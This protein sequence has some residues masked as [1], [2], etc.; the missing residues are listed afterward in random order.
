MRPIAFWKERAHLYVITFNRYCKNINVIIVGVFRAVTQYCV[1]QLGVIYKPQLGVATPG[2]YK[3]ASAPTFDSRMIPHER[4][5][6][7]KRRKVSA[8]RYKSA[9]LTV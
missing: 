7:R 3:G 5:Y 1:I 4:L 6:R 9:T 2:R 8:K